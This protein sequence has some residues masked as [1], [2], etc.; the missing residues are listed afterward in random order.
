[1]GLAE[2]AVSPF[3]VR[4]FYPSQH[5]HAC[6][7]MCTHLDTSPMPNTL[8]FHTYTFMHTPTY[9]IFKQLQMHLINE[10]IFSKCSVIFI[11]VVDVEECMKNKEP[12]HKCWSRFEDG[13]G[14]CR[15][16]SHTHHTWCNNKSGYKYHVI[17]LP[18]YNYLLKGHDHHHYIT[19]ISNIV[20]YYKILKSH[21]T[22]MK[23][24][25]F[26][27]GWSMFIYHEHYFENLEV[28]CNQSLFK[29]MSSHSAISS[30]ESNCILLRS[31]FINID[32]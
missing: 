12:T 30:K 21:Q 24:V 23:V 1:M 32:L 10:S 31:S 3:V 27:I 6:T 15:M 16:V 5:N 7:Y 2:R 4:D 25:K 20:K 9:F 11:F 8:T 19:Y 14:T 28:Q 26:E 13:G 18:T 29:E 22:D 17:E